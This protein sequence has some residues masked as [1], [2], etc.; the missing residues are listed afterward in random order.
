VSGLVLEDEKV[1]GT[2]HIAFGNNVGFGGA[3]DVAFHVDGVVT[4]PTLEVDGEVLIRA[5]R[6]LFV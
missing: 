6:P 3:N 4:A 1:L 5:G 2:V